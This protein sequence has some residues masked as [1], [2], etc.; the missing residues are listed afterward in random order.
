VKLLGQWTQRLRQEAYCR[1]LDRQLAG[2]G[3][4]ET[5][6]GADDVAEIPVLERIVRIGTDDVG[7]HIELDPAAHVLDR[8]EAGFA[9]HP[10]Q[11]H[12][13]G[14][15]H[16]PVQRLQLFVAARVVRGVQIR[17]ERIAP[18]VIGK[19]VALATQGIE[20][21]AALGND[22]VFVRRRRRGGTLPEP[23]LFLL[24][25]S[26]PLFQ[27]CRDEIIEITVEHALSIADFVVGAQVLDPRLIENVRADLV[28]PNRCRSSNPRAFA[29]LPAACATRARTA[30][31]S[32]S[33]SPRRDCGAA[34]DRSGIG[35]QC[36]SV[37][38]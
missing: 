4:E 18:E 6:T 19:S 9:H 29:A 22:L 28:S 32:T 3:L 8:R 20:F 26:N 27:A 17:G 14:N 30:A 11:H 2:L 38:A 23:P 16:G 21:A 24:D 10:L 13:A 33:P 15:R 12:S 25:M 37:R 36:P 35:R 31:T 7:R 1:D 5:S 34:S